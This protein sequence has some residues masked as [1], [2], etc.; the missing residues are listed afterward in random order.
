V[1]FPNFALYN[2]PINRTAS[3]VNFGES[4]AW[5]PKMKPSEA[6]TFDA[7]PL[8]LAKRPYSAIDY[9]G[10][11]RGN[12]VAFRYHGSHSKKGSIWLCKC[13]CG[14]YEFRVVGKWAKKD[15]D[16]ACIVCRATHFATKGYSL[17][18]TRT[19]ADRKKGLPK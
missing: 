12:L 14:K 15:A 19:E 3:R 6:E 13:D 16:D 18:D 11:R 4:D 7:P 5:V 17:G 8:P 10:F 1:S 9:S 2:K